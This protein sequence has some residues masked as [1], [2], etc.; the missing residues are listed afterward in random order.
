MKRI[1]YLLFLV[2]LTSIIISSCSDRKTYA[3]QLDD[4]KNLIAAYIKRND[5]KVLSTFPKD[6]VWKTN[7]YVLTTSGLYIHMISYGDV[8]ST[9]SLEYKDIVV[10]RYKQYT[11]D[12]VPDTLY[13]W[14][15]IDFPQPPVFVYGDYSQSC[16]G[17]QEAV[18]Y[19]KRNDSEAKLIVPSKLGFSNYLTSVTPLGYELKIKIQK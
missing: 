5:I 4:E 6:S 12:M 1:S 13:N 10:P 11:L 19:M 14:S 17:F 18:S 16:I 15:T 2:F 9:D 3:Q 7:D 8:S